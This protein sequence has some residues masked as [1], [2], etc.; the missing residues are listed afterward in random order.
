VVEGDAVIGI[1]SIGALRRVPREQWPFVRVRDVMRPLDE[2]LTVRPTD[3]A[4]RALERA[5][6]NKLGR[7]A[8]MDGTRL[9]GYLSMQDIT[10]VLA[11]HGLGEHG[12]ATAPRRAA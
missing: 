2:T 11:L 7:L 3:S 8:V 5:S 9:V 4:Q 1:A 6:S 12:R 10:H